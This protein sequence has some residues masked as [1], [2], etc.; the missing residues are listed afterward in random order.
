MIY[1][2]PRE[3]LI[4]YIL[5]E[6]FLI[7]CPVS[8]FLIYFFLQIFI[9]LQFNNICLKNALPFNFNE[10]A[11][12]SSISVGSN[13]LGRKVFDLI[14]PNANHSS[15][16]S[17]LAHTYMDAPNCYICCM[18]QIT[19]FAICQVQMNISLHTR[20]TGLSTKFKA[21]IKKICLSLAKLP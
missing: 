11:T 9:L 16:T 7:S 20:G 12:Q 8:S 19:S 15:F 21:K 14:N 4:I 3:F 18:L 2:C 1:C 13:F 17:C 6:I 5:L 10:C